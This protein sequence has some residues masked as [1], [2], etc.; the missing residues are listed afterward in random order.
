MEF[1]ILGLFAFAAGFIDSV[2]G[3]GGLIQLPG[4]MLVFPGVPFPVL[5]GTNKLSSIC[6]TT[7]AAY[8]YKKDLK[9]DKRVLVAAVPCALLASWFGARFVSYLNPALVKPVV[10]VSLLIVGLYTAFKPKLGDIK[11][12]EKPAK[13]IYI[14]S[15][16]IGLVIGFYDGFIGPGTGSFLIFAFIMMLGLDFLH[17][18]ASAKIV[19]IA[20]NIAAIGY[21]VS[22][23]QFLPWHALV[24]GLANICGSALGTK[25]ALDKGN[26]WIKKVFLVSVTILLGKL[27]WD[28]SK[29]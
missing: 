27:I 12:K 28:I 18:S 9:F 26:E 14:S 15:A 16:L 24:M 11:P 21:F 1:L 7:Y 8:R 3:G 2:A 17:A 23:G 6:G 13:A 5:A 4:L 19:N 22:T 25:M 29:G 10:I 20:T